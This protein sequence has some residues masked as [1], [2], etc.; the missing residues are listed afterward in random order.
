MHADGVGAATIFGFRK[1]CVALQRG[2]MGH[3]QHQQG[4]NCIAYA[5][6]FDQSLANNPEMNIRV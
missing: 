6:R 2:I 5:Q 3:F 4:R 1:T